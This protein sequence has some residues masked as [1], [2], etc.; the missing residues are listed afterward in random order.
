MSKPF[1][2][3]HV[4]VATSNAINYVDRCQRVVDD[5]DREQRLKAQKCKYCFYAG[6]MV[7]NAFEKKPC[8][9]CGVEVV[10]AHIPANKLC[11]SCAVTHKLCADCGAD[12]ELK[13]RRKL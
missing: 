7:L 5:V 3:Y 8:G 6:K 4:E 9:L 1:N 2:L 11:M 13:R 10:S 12:V